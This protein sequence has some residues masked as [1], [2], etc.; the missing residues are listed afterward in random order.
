MDHAELIR[1]VGPALW[2]TRW[3]TDMAE[4]L[5]VNDRTVRRWVSG[6]E[7]PRP[8]VWTELIAIIRERRDALGELLAVV[9]QHASER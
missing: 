9:E 5:G 1:T 7:V 6:R 2:G 4:R 3:Q 8:G